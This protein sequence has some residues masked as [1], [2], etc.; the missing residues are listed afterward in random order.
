MLITLKNILKTTD[1]NLV[2]MVAPPLSGKTTV[3]K[4]IA[5]YVTVVSRDD[6][7]ME[8]GNGLNYSDSFKTV[9]QK[10]VDKLLLKRLLD[11]SK[12]NENVVI[13]M[14][15]LSPKRRK[16]H[17][18]KFPKHYKIACILDIPKIE[19]LYERNEKRYEEEN[20]FIPKHIIDSMYK[21]IKYPTKEE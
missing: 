20:K 2:I 7:V 4:E 5:D 14:T 13:D 18:S 17:I 9:N 10:E 21:S 15:N 19:V 1:S 11:L 12:T 16:G 3:I 6:I 8:L